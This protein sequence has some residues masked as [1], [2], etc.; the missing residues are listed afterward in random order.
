[1]ANLGDW[2]NFLLAIVPVIKLIVEFIESLFSS[3]TG[4]EKKAQAMSIAKKV[5][6]VPSANVGLRDQLLSTAIDDQVS[7]L[8]ASGVFTHKGSGVDLSF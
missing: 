8:N 1:M 4:A 5:L 7:A 2:A 3:S 6:S